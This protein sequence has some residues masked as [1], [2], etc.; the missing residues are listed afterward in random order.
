MIGPIGQ[1]KKNSQP[2]W[3]QKNMSGLKSSLIYG[4]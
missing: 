2:G 1:R 3:K 4:I